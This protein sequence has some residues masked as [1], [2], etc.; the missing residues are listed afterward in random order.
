MLG[1][2]VPAR[3]EL[4][5]FA[6]T[7]PEQSPKSQQAVHPLHLIVCSGSSSLAPRHTPA[8]MIACHRDPAAAPGDLP[9][10][11]GVANIWPSPKPSEAAKLPGHTELRDLSRIPLATIPKLP[12]AIPELGKFPTLGVLLDIRA[13]AC[14]LQ[15]SN[16]ESDHAQPGV[17]TSTFYIPTETT[18]LYGLHS[19]LHIWTDSLTR[20]RAH[21]NVDAPQNAPHISH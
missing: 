10:A 14:R 13:G 9:R 7:L 1:L 16:V 6:E 8:A 17:R 19:L 12:M 3:L 18:A 4:S 11:G 2:H 15:V 20:V 5:Q 21:S